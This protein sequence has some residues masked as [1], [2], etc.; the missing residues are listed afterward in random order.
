[1]QLAGI[2]INGDVSA[3][4]SGE[5]HM[6]SERLRWLVAAEGPFASVYFDDSHDTLDAVERREATWRD[7]RKHLESRDAKQEL[8]DSLE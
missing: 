1:R 2:C 3:K 4:N 5:N 8:I 7:V 6:R